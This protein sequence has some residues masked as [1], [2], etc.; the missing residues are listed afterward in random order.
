MKK[1][2]ITGAN[3]FIGMSFEEYLG[4]FGDSY[5]VDT[6]D[7]IDGS[8][9]DMDMSG[10]DAVFHVAGLAHQKETEDNANLYYAV[11]RDLAIE[12]AKKAK[13]DGVGQFVFLSTMSVYGIN[14]GIIT[15]ETIPQPKSNYGSSKLQAEEEINSLSDEFFAV[16]ILRP[17]MVYGMGC[18]GNFQTVVKIAMKSPVFPKINNMRSMIHI[19]NLCSFVKMCVD[20]KLSGLFFPQNR[21]YVR[22]DRLAL[23]VAKKKNKPLY[24]SV[25]C[26]IGVVLLKPFITTVEK[27]FGTLIYKDT[28]DFDFRYCV[29]D[30]EKSVE[31]SV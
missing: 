5:Q 23:L 30:F 19:R 1:V 9:R 21:E 28:E 18:R 27:A 2:L 14:S 26:G 4:S 22:T 15:K 20:K 7:M 11:N 3:S 13:A 10:Y 29:V 6:V 25:L 8:W 16:A 12:V 24:L 31:E 17:P